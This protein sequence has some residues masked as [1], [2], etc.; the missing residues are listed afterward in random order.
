MLSRMTDGQQLPLDGLDLAPA[1]VTIDAGG[2]EW[3]ATIEGP[4]AIAIRAGGADAPVVRTVRTPHGA[5][6][7]ARDLRGQLIDWTSWYRDDLGQ[8]RADAREE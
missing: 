8:L 7:T 1:A 4:E 5:I 2:E 3:S 6:R